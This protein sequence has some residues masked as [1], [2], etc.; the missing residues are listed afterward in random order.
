VN[1]A[2]LRPADIRRTV[3]AAA[4]CSTLALTA[5][6]G[7]TG[8]ARVEPVE[9]SGDGTLRVGLILDSTG[10]NAFL[11]APQLA[12][13]KLAVQEINAAG[14]HK[15]KPVELLPTESG[16]DA[17]G[18]AQA[19]V[20]A[21]ADVVIGPTDSS[22]AAAA[23]DILSRAR[24]P[25]ISPANTAAGLSTANSG[26]YYF[27]TAAADVA[28]G[29]V[30]VKLARDAGANTVAVMYQEGSYGKDVSAAVAASAGQAGLAV[31]ATAGFKPGEA[32]AAAAAVDKA[33]ADA[34]IVIARDGAQGALAE[35]GNAGVDGKRI[36]L[37]DGAFARYGSRLPAKSLDGG[38]AV[39]A[40]QLP[41]A[42]FQARLLTV[43]PG[44]KDVSFAAEAYDAVTVAALAAAR[45]QDDAG[46]SIAANLIAASGGTVEGSPGK[47]AAEACLTYKD[48]RAGLM[49]GPD[50]NY[51]G[52]SGPVAFDANG[53]ITTAT[54]T[55]YTY[56]ADN[57]PAPS[58]RETAG[59]AA[60]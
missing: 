28:Q 11:N 56:G 10:D 40:G 3:L 41:E 20:A 24:T 44:L 2:F 43:D 36:I 18:Q 12:A 34:V 27:R 52:E 4:A 46:R 50:I 14:G 26:G 53:D 58:G 39:V 57:N 59:R 16:Q 38:R 37:S 33:N 35:L 48:C 25:L 21:K 22:H 31:A 49:S 45:A 8:N 54:F 60:G 13:A 51:D 29:P 23:I 55:V 7:A 1:S 47:P 17:A 19:L 32:G 30:L 5:C 42:D 6:S 9:A 15:G